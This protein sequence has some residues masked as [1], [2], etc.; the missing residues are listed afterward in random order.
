MAVTPE[1]N[2]PQADAAVVYNIPS[3]SVRTTQAAIDFVYRKV[4]TSLAVT[5]AGAYVVVLGTVNNPK[6][7]AWNY[8]LDGH[9]FYVLRLGSSGKTLIYDNSTGMW[10][11]YTSGQD[12]K[13]RVN[14]GMNWPSSGSIPSLK[15]TNIVCGD[16]T[17]GTLWILDSE[18]AYDEGDPGDSTQYP[19]PRVVSA[20]LPT[21]DRDAQ[22]VYSVNLTASFGDP[23]FSPNTVSLSYSDDMGHTYQTADTPLMEITGAYNLEFQW[24]SMGQY[25]SP[26]RLFQIADNGT[27]RRIDDMS[28][29]DSN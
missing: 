4:T 29:N 22:P 12:V 10:S 17:T 13:W 23:G 16:D 15:G 2:A 18:T 11:W 3:L 21:R 28:V 26:G 27:F 9:D 25:S 7:R 19:F 6:L 5:E 24:R 14:T 8:T 1:I 20:Q